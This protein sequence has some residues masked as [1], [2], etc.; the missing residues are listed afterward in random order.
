MFER[1]CPDSIAPI[2]IPHRIVFSELAAGENSRNEKLTRR[3]RRE[4]KGADLTLTSCVL[5]FFLIL[6]N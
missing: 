4:R 2:Q 1:T 6:F 5:L 3:I